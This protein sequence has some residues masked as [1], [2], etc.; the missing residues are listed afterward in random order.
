MNLYPIL[1]KD[2]PLLIFAL[3]LEEAK[4]PYDRLTLKSNTTSE[5]KSLLDK[6]KDIPLQECKLLLSGPNISYKDILLAQKNLQTFARHTQ[7]SYSEPPIIVSKE[8]ENAFEE[9]PIQVKEEPKTEITLSDDL[10]SMFDDINASS[11]EIS[12]PKRIEVP[13]IFG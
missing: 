6:A 1:Y 5:F 7:N 9:P 8:L 2:T 3:N 4:I 13:D 12:P 11:E 10:S